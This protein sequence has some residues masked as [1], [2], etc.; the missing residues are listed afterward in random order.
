MR[1]RLTKEAFIYVL[2]QLDLSE[3]IRSTYIPPVLR[4]AIT[5]TV[6]ASGGYQGVVSN[7]FI[8]P[9][10][11]TT[12]SSVLDEV[13]FKAEECIC[14]KWIKL[15][16]NNESCKQYFFQKYNIPGGKMGH[17]TD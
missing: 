11:K 3:G 6:L 5:L 10:S 9:V 14:N 17:Y 16:K 2:K 1:F 7:D 13:L 15:S 12:V 8:C 4:L